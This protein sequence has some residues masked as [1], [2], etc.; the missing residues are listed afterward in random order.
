MKKRFIYFL[1]VGMIVLTGCQKE[2]SFE[3]GNNPGKATLQE[4]ASGDCLPKTVNGV[5]EVATPL[6]PGTNN[7]TVDLDV[8]ETGTYEITTDTV[9]GFYFRATGIF[10]TMGMNTITLR[11]NGTP[12]AAGV[13]NFVVSFDG[14]SCDI[15]V[16]VLPAGAGGPAVFTLETTGTTPPLSCSGATAAGTYIIG[17]PLNSSNTVTL[18]VNVTTIGTFTMT[19]TATNGMTFEKTGVFLNTGI[20]NV[21]LVGTGTPSGTAGAIQ[22]PITV[23]ATTCN[24]TVNIVAGAEFSFDCGSA[25]VNGVYE[26]GVALGA[27]NTV[28]IDVNVTTAGPY[29]ISVTVNGM[30]F[31]QSG[32]FTA[33]PASITLTATGTPAAD[34][35]F[36]VN[37]PGTTP[38]SFSVVV[39]PGTVPSDLIWKFT[40]GTTIYQ[41]TIDFA[42]V[43]PAGGFESIGMMGSNA[44][45]DVNFNLSLTKSG[46]LGTGVYKSTSIPSPLATL[47][48]TDGSA[49]PLFTAVGPPSD[50][51]VTVQE[52]N[53]TTKV[54]RGIFSGKV[55][56][57]S[58]STTVTI[59]NGEFKAEIQ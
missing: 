3:Q 34:G 7:I 17:S 9:N 35:T 23:G 43:L 27:G 26:E 2:L 11:G 45:G 28:D 8:T 33:G 39:D 51:T 21:T 6:V 55:V 44:A 47:M 13:H 31:A 49:N 29:N 59:T 41:G 36:A 1:A 58:G 22:V 37:M 53:L 30:T 54:I 24:F 48:V 57:G 16:T 40:H 15:Q 5:Y 18:S 19:S 14:S 50:L 56:Q 20:Q 10:T 25:T 52:Y 12:F 46:T 42:P 32:T 4:E 38:C